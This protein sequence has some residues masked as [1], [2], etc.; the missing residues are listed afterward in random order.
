MENTNSL[1]T[2]VLTIANLLLAQ[3]KEEALKSF[4]RAISIFNWKPN[5]FGYL[6]KTEYFFCYFHFCEPRAC[7]D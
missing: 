2:R 4:T 1:N 6:H 3:K 7:R 5:E